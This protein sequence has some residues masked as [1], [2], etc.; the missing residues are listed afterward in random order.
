[1]DIWDAVCKVG[2][3]IAVAIYLLVRL[4]PKVDSMG[5]HVDDVNHTIL[6]LID[7]V[8]EDVDNTKKNAE[9]TKDFT[10]AIEELRTEIRRFNN[11]N[12]KK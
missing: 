11:G 3:P 4:E 2:F 12:N 9:A 1:M 10:H 5:K 8:K 7:V 6:A